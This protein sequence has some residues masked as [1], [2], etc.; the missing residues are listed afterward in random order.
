MNNHLIGK[1]ASWCFNSTKESGNPILMKN[2]EKMEPIDAFKRL[3]GC[4]PYEEPTTF[5]ILFEKYKYEARL[6]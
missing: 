4:K 1:I 2:K 5:K 3:T 6:V